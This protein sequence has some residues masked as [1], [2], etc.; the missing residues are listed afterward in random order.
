MHKIL[1]V[2]YNAELVEGAGH[3]QTPLSTGGLLH[4]LNRATQQ[5]DMFEHPNMNLVEIH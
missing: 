4:T 3:I 2:V 1:Q 5:D